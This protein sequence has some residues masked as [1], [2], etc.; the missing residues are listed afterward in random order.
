MELVFAFFVILALATIGVLEG[1][2]VFLD[3]LKVKRPEWLMVVLTMLVA[4]GFSIMA[5]IVGIFN[6]PFGLLYPAV[7]AEVLIGVIAGMVAFAITKLA[8]DL[9]V[10][11]LLAAVQRLIDLLTG[12]KEK[13]TE[14]GL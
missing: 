10:R 9:C 7:W 12:G 2:K 3:A 8:Y 1:L 13:P 5:A 4:E 11:L 6:E 14:G